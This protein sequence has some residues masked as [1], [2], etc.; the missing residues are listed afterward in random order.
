MTAALFDLPLSKPAF[1]LREYQKEAVAAGIS[2]M[3]KKNAPWIIVLPTWSGK[4]L[5]IANIIK[6]LEGKTI[7]LQP[8]KEIL[9]QNF[10][11]FMTYAPDM[12]AWIFSA[13]FGKKEVK[14]VTFAMIWS[15]I[16]N[17]E[18]FR[19]FHNII[20]DECHY[21]NAK[22][23]MYNEFIQMLEWTNVLWLTATPY[24]LA[25]NSYWSMLRFITRTRPRIFESVIYH[26]QVQDL[27]AFWFLADVNYYQIQGF[28]SSKVKANSTGADYSD[29]SLRQ[30]Y[31][32]I[33]FDNSITDVVKRLVNAGRKNILVFTRFTE[34]A[35]SL[36]SKL[37]EVASIVT[38]ETKPKDREKLLHDFKSWKIKVMANVGVL[39]TWFDFPE[40]ETVVLAR[41]TKS[42]SL[43][44]QM[45]GR[46]IR[47]HKD[48]KECWVVDMCENI[49][50]FG[51]V[52]DLYLVD[53]WRG[54]RVVKSQWRELTNVN[55]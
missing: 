41:P 22:G 10:E 17:K 20:I 33:N 4:S 42:L 48:K 25:S 8:S 28:E 1:E 44:Y 55:L 19:D 12:D 29:G 11:K 15:V 36:V 30:Y 50:R 32:D 54:K 51:R 5:V 18:L 49:H 9:E 47:P 52:E 7:I 24:R 53:T 39:T 35:H 13:S 14:D 23:G 43:Y 37:W 16:N 34:E 31:R 45:V 40:L 6:Q 21:V 2:H 27:K 3:Q 46:W 38:A 26:S